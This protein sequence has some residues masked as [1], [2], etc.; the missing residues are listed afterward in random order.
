MQFALKILLAALVGQA[1]AF[2]AQGPMPLRGARAVSP[3][4]QFGTGNADGNGCETVLHAEPAPLLRHL[5]SHTW[6]LVC[7][8][9]DDE[10]GNPNFFLSPIAGGSKAS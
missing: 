6:L 2:V 5:E 9:A 4:A 1:S 7:A 3:V 8:C 10:K